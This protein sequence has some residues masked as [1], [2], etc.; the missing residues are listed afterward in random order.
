MST[1]LEK[2]TKSAKSQRRRSRRSTDKDSVVDK[3]REERIKSKQEETLVWGPYK[4][5]PTKFRLKI[6]ENGET[7]NVGFKTE[8][9]AEEVKA[10][11]LGRDAQRCERTIGTTIQE[12]LR[13]LSETRCIKPQSVVW[14]ARNLKWLPDKVMLSNLTT[15]QAGLLYRKEFTER[16]LNTNRPLAA[17]THRV[18][19]ALA[20]RFYAWSVKSGFCKRNP[21]A[22]VQPV[23]RVNVGKKQLR[24]DEARRLESFCLVQAREGDVSAVGALLMMYLGLRQG[25][26]IARVG[27]DIDDDGRVLWVTSGKT[28]NAKRRLKIPEQLRPLIQT[29]VQTRQPDDLLFFPSK[30]NPHPN[31]YWL[32]VRRLCRLAGVTVVCAHSLR[33]LHATLALDGGATADAV[34]RALGHGSF[35][36]TERHYASASSVADSK[37]N[38]VAETLAGESTT[39]IELV[40]LLKEWPA[41]RQLDLLAQVRAE[42]PHRQP[43]DESHQT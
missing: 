6:T 36:M 10:K 23:G 12:F 16:N 17:A 2:I 43:L 41:E 24:I 25:E 4:D 8:E 14:A 27:R 39:L 1:T 21:F 37:T 13:Y 11:L 26:V 40:S 32:Q 15:E 28:K 20:R 42:R 35:S 31:Y 38:R 5:G 7:R 34:A 3:L 29:L 33:G 9:E 19:L 30:G 22:E 18:R